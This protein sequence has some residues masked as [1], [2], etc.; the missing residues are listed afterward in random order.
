MKYTV[1]IIQRTETITYDTNS[2]DPNRIFSI[3]IMYFL[4]G[5]TYNTVKHIMIEMPHD[6]NY[7]GFIL[8]M[9]IKCIEKIKCTEITQNLFFSHV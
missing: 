6:M 1:Y 5:I 8:K 9:K 3:Y 7:A 4:F 2:T